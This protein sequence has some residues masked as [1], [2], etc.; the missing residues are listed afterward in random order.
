VSKHR[1]NILVHGTMEMFALYDPASP[2]VEIITHCH[3]CG[4]DIAR[5]QYDTSDPKADRTVDADAKRDGE[6]ALA[7]F[8][9]CARDDRRAYPWEA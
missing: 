7:H 2:I 4:L 1:R 6:A 8:I 9:H 3:A 5:R